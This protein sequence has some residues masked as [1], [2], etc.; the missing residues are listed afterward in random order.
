MTRVTFSTFVVLKFFS[1]FYF[2]LS[3]DRRIIHSVK[4]LW[5]FLDNLPSCKTLPINFE[6]IREK[7]PAII[8]EKVID[9]VWCRLN[10]ENVC[11]NINGNIR[12]GS[13]R[14]LRKGFGNFGS[15]STKS[16][17]EGI[18]E[19]H[20]SNVKKNFRRASSTLCLDNLPP[21]PKMVPALR[22]D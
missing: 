17:D 4:S 20:E 8:R 13:G 15:Y 22:N 5:W 6:L 14:V 21:L 9:L 19:E 10:N 3:D 12:V 1:E 11:T 18:G 7:C 2:L 16:F